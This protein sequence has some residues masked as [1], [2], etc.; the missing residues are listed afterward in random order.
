MKYIQKNVPPISFEKYKKTEGA[1]FKDLYD[2]QTN[3][4]GDLKKSLIAEQG[5]I[6]CYCGAQINQ[7]NSVIEHF[8]PQAKDCF[9][10]LQLEYCNLLASCSGGQCER[11]T[12]KKF[13]LSCD[14]KKENRL[15]EVSPIDPNCES[16]FEYDDEGNIYGITSKAQQAIKVLNLNNAFIKNQRKAAIEAYINLPIETDWQ[17]EI[18]CLSSRNQYGLYQPYCFAV[19]YY[20]KHFLAPF[21]S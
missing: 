3:I 20:I 13:P 16:Y 7:N 1:S 12:N 10:E 21:T 4:K 17:D 5:G 15:I 6:C 14:A 2:N 9:P 11:Q 18:R 8:K 19:T